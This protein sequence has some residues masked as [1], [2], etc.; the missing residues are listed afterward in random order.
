[1]ACML[2]VDVE[3]V[4]N[5][6]QDDVAARDGAWETVRASEPN[7]QLSRR[8]TAGG[9]SLLRARYVID[10]PL[11]RAVSMGRPEVFFHSGRA[12]FDD[13]LEGC[14]VEHVIAPGDAN[15]WVKFRFT[16]LVQ[17]SRAIIGTP[18][19]VI[20]A[21]RGAPQNAADHTEVTRMRLMVRRDWPQ[22]GKFTIA[23]IPRHPETD[24]LVEELGIV[25]ATVAVLEAAEDPEK[26]LITEVKQVKG[27]PTWAFALGGGH[28]LDWQSLKFMARYR[29]SMVY[30][31]ATEGAE[32][33]I[34]VRLRKYVKGPPLL[35]SNTPGVE[36]EPADLE[37]FTLPAYLR[38]FLARLGL[39]IEAYGSLDGRRLVPYQAAVRRGAWQ[40][41]WAAMEGPF[42]SQKVAYRRLLGGTNAPELKVGVEPR[43]VPLDGR[44]PVDARGHAAAIAAAP[45]RVPLPVRS[46]FVHFSSGEETTGGLQRCGSTPVLVETFQEVAAC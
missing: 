39:D 13:E 31:E 45:P 35:P 4:F 41:A 14:G 33:Y 3:S 38:S 5:R 2:P 37:A 6:V 46:T 1:M 17:R 15:V 25:Q 18:G 42:L 19:A 30:R 26:T 32:S 23:G 34:I 12:T 22:P 44:H 10:N 11:S 24:E 36:W 20:R 40:H 29:A 43:F 21:I 8:E 16:P 27:V 9:A 7:L 28:Y